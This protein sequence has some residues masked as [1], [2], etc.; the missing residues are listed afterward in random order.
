MDQITLHNYIKLF[1]KGRLS[2]THEKELLSWIRESEAN[3]QLF[4]REQN[5]I[6]K[7][8][9]SDHNNTIHIKWQELRNKIKEEN[10]YN[11][12][13]VI[14]LISSIVAAFIAGV[15]I[16]V[17][18]TDIHLVPDNHTVQH[19]NITV[20]YGARTST[21]L[22]DGS[23]VWLNAGT[24]LSYPTIFDESRNV[25]L[26]GE[27][28]FEVV[29]N[30]TPFRVKT[31]YGEVEVKGTSFNVKAYTNEN[32]QTTLIEGSVVLRD[33]ASRK[34]V[35][36]LPGQ[37]GE[38]ANDKI[39]VKN[40]STE[41]YTSWTEG[42]IIFHKAY[43]PEVAERLERWYNVKIVLDKDPRLNKIWFTGT[44]EMETFSEVLELLKVTAPIDYSY[45]ENERVIKIKYRQ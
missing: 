40:V 15:L 23:K 3:R 45:N 43:M 39:L 27:A 18:L 32:L 21:T 38:L 26:N 37:L 31:E 2:E 24:T 1:L 22:P 19:Q 20:P 14:V 35:T 6:S 30:D 34:E 44:L 12:R 36:L 11:S 7:D 42:R 33:I 17:L 29:K 41:L 4:I 25:S 13:S 9:I 28:Y 8:L 10:S 5:I 16:T